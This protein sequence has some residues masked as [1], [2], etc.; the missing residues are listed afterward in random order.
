MNLIVGGRGEPVH[1][2]P[3]A[4]GAPLLSEADRRA[5]A[6]ELRVRPSA[7]PLQAGVELYRVRV[8]EQVPDEV[9]PHF[10]ADRPEPLAQI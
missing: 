9:H 8:G 4:G 5:E 2:D 1:E 10:G 6:R 7:N 3:C